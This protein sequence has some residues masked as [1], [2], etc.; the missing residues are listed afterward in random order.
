MLNTLFLQVL[1]MSLTASYVILMVLLLR[2][3]LNQAPKLC[4]YALWAV[5]LVRLLCPFSIEGRFSLIPAQGQYTVDTAISVA[6]TVSSQPAPS[7]LTG[8]SGFEAVWHSYPFQEVSEAV[9]LLQVLVTIGAFL[10]LSVTLI[11]LFRCIRQSWKLWRKLQGT[12]T[13]QG[14]IYRSAAV[15]APFV[16][17]IFRPTIYLPAGLSSKE[18][19]YILFHEKTHIRR[20]DHITRLLAY[21]ACCIHWFNPLVW[22][23]YRISEQ[24]MELAC[25][26]RVLSTLGRGITK[27]YSSSI[28]H[29]T[30][31]RSPAGST[32]TFG[33]GDTDER[34]RRALFYK[35]PAFWMIL[36]AVVLAAAVGMG[37]LVNPAA[38]FSVETPILAEN[39]YQYSDM[40]FGYLT[41]STRYHSINLWEV[42]YTQGSEEPTLLNSTIR[43]PLA[44]DCILYIGGT[45]SEGYYNKITDPEEIEKALP[46]FYDTNSY[47]SVFGVKCNKDGQVSLIQ[48][49]LIE[50]EPLCKGWFG[51]VTVENG[52]LI[53]DQAEWITAEDTQRIAELGLE[54]EDSLKNGGFYIYN[55]TSSDTVTILLSGALSYCDPYW[56]YESGSQGEAQPREMSL[57]ELLDY[58]NRTGSPILCDVYQDLDGHWTQ[59][60]EQ[61]L[62]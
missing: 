25:D 33:S 60:W 21:L 41:V 24:D 42:T 35:R 17:G 5:V 29:F 40:T 54:E 9:S 1:K 50:P 13:R 38:A 51:Y 31:G 39:A 3:V 55:P 49:V 14:Q 37:L 15:D 45:S 58:L 12:C 8:E 32:L 56:A 16:M 26:E 18:E 20:L 44:E 46:Y 34:I 11:L 62:P 53:I 7:S 28:L 59:I 43:L 10:W 22:L 47:N 30:A 48:E 61:Y 2:L 23:A 6:Q 52:A 19:E 57:Q 27:Q 36:V 4:S